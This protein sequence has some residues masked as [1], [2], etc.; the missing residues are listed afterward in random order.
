MNS[1]LS[2]EFGWT[3]RPKPP[4]S[5][6]T[7]MRCPSPPARSHRAA[8]AAR[9]RPYTVTPPTSTTPLWAPPS[10]PR[11][12]AR[13]LQE[14]ASDWAS[15]G[16]AARWHAIGCFSW[17]VGVS[18]RARCAL[19]GAADGGSGGGGGS[20]ME[21][22]LSGIRQLAAQTR[23][24]PL[25][26]RGAFH[27]GRSSSREKRREGERE[28]GSRRCQPAALLSGKLWTDLMAGSFFQ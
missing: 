5:F 2:G 26:E 23:G 18:G 4:S 25:V 6:P 28:R 7:T 1:F 16:G 13:R 14:A 15:P 3:P 9:P 27:G 17:R 8:P 20:S 11:S 19:L 22:G 10:C 12:R 21:T 24:L